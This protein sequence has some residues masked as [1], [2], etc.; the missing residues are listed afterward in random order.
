MM[1]HAQSS[2][3]EKQAQAH[4]ILSF[5]LKDVSL[6][7]LSTFH[8]FSNLE[9]LYCKLH[10]GFHACSTESNVKADSWH[11]VPCKKTYMTIVI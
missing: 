5:N 1:T 10:Q 9:A 6:T 2:N 3:L 7:L 11:K 8:V 4:G